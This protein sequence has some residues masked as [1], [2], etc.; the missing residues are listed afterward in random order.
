MLKTIR[1]FIILT[2]ILNLNAFKFP[3]LTQ[4]SNTKIV[5]I[6]DIETKQFSSK[7]NCLIDKKL[8]Y[9]ICN[10]DMNKNDINKNDINKN[11]NKDSELHKLFIDN[12]NHMDKKLIAISPAGLK[13]FYLLGVMSYIKEHYDTSDYIFSGASAGGFISLFATYKY[14]PLDI[15]ELL[16][17]ENIL[18]NGD[19]INDLQK[20][21]KRVLLDNFST[22]DFELNK[23]SIGVTTIQNFNLK[24]NIYFDFIDLED[25][26]DACIAS[27]N[28]P[29]ITGDLFHKYNNA[30]SFDGGFSKYPFFHLIEPSLHITADIWNEKK[31]EDNKK[32]NYGL[33]NVINDFL[34]FFSKENYNFIDL[35]NKGYNDTRNN[36]NR[37]ENMLKIDN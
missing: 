14:N 18:L 31:S 33:F 32:N 36:K 26:I 13:G 6:N 5:N 24:T 22:D 37:L 30:Y 4:Y 3:S 34:T 21:I 25:A 16:D 28:I 23:L 10:L 15:V 19:N 2:N 27:S 29:F 20:N 17:I 11:H 12:I 1:T 35:Y 8:K 7:N 9:E